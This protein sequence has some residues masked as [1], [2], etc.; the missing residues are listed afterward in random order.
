MLEELCSQLE[1]RSGI[2]DIGLARRNLIVY[3]SL[4]N[5]YQTVSS[6][7][8]PPVPRETVKVLRALAIF[9]FDIGIQLFGGIHLNVSAHK[10]FILVGILM[11]WAMV[12]IIIPRLYEFSIMCR[13]MSYQLKFQEEH[14][15]SLEN[16]AARNNARP[17]IPTSVLTLL[18]TLPA[19]NRA[20]EPPRRQDTEAD[21]AVVAPAS[22]S[23]S[24]PGNDSEGRELS[25]TVSA[26]GE[27]SASSPLSE[28]QRT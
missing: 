2:G 24:E 26:A 27:E 16:F 19:E 20:V 22:V 5:L 14:Q 3:S 17:D 28:R 13:L 1:A 18:G 7:P 25:V 10:T 6:D 15:G 8:N 23:G 4:C 11:L 12:R 9:T 21:I